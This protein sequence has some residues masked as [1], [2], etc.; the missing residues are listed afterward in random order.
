MNYYR[1]T[2]VLSDGAGYGKDFQDSSRDYSTDKAKP[3]PGIVSRTALTG[4][5]R[6][7]FNLRS[8]GKNHAKWEYKGKRYD[9]LDELGGDLRLS[10]ERMQDYAQKGQF[11]GYPIIKVKS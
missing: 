5:N 3:Y 6:Q 9:S 8:I 1:S 11:E 4:P 7:L 10:L 2:D